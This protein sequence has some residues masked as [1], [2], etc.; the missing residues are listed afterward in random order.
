MHIQIRPQKKCMNRAEYKKKHTALLDQLLSFVKEVE[1]KIQRTIL[2]ELNRRTELKT[3]LAFVSTAGS[4]T[5]MW[6]L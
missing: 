2:Y 6:S 5:G 3:K 4:D 1:L